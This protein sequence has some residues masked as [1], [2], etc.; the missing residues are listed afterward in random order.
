VHGA[1]PRQAGEA[2]ARLFSTPYRWREKFAT[3]DPMTST[4]ARARRADRVETN[5]GRLSLD[6][7]RP[8]SP[9]VR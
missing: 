5:S 7:E 6:P 9:P 3:M 4:G 2:S 1:S 8:L